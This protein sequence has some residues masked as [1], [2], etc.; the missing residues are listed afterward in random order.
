MRQLKRLL[1]SGG[2]GLVGLLLFV[3]SA[4]AASIPQNQL[5]FRDA[6]QSAIADIKATDLPPEGLHTLELIKQGG[7]FPYSRDGV[8]FHNRERRLPIRA[9]GYYRE[10]TVPTPGARN[11]GARRIIAGKSSEYFYTNDHYRSFRLIKE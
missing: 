9:K 11:R 5:A 4:S 7:P 6:D 1:I 10:Y 2:I 3:A 8:T